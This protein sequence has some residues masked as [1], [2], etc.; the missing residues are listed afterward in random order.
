MYILLLEVV[1]KILGYS[2][3][4]YGLW[5][6][7]APAINPLI[8]DRITKI[9]RKN[10]I[11]RVNELANYEEKPKQQS[12]LFNHLELILLATKKSVQTN[13][14]ANFIFLSISIFVVSTLFIIILTED[15]FIGFMIGLLFGLL[16]YILVRI[17]L[18]SIQVKSSIAFAN[19]FHVII[20]NYQSTNKDMYFTVINAIKQIREPNLKITFIKLANAMQ[21]QKNPIDF[22]K[23]EKVFIYSINSQFAKRFGKLLIKSHI[24]RAD[25][26]NSLLHLDADIRKRKIDMEEEKTQRQDTVTQGFFPIVALPFA[27]FISYQMAG[28]QDYWYFFTQKF[29]LTLFIICVVLSL[30][31]VLIASVLKKPKTDI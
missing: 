29:T 18:M 5:L 7:I 8:Y 17:K 9:K 1:F 11:K 6:L 22:A 30:I 2:M 16:P 26:F 14:V 13:G 27:F 3:F 24:Y 12:G 19:N 21:L 31:S 28:V 10:R 25:V 20:T 23:A 4:I 15:L